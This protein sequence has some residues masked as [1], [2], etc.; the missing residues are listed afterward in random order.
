MRGWQLGYEAWE[1]KPYENWDVLMA[2]N[3]LISN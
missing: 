2:H 3:P 1:M